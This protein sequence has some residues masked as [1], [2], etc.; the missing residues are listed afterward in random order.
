[1]TSSQGGADCGSQCVSANS[2]TKQS[3]YEF[4]DT[5]ICS[6]NLLQ[7]L[8]SNEVLQGHDPILLLDCLEE[9]MDRI[10]ESQSNLMLYTGF[11]HETVYPK[12]KGKQLVEKLWIELHDIERA[13]PLEDVCDT[14]HRLLHKDLLRNQGQQWSNYNAEWETI[15]V[16]MEGMILGDLMEDAVRDLRA[17]LPPNPFHNLPIEAVTRRQL[18]AF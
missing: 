4:T 18:F 15:G 7:C 16:D 10:L 2:L 17:L 9:I 8:Q 12:P 1:M 3:S 6:G 14:V 5:K 11:P 13:P